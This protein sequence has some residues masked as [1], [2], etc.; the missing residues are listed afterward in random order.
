MSSTGEAGDLPSLTAGAPFSGPR[1]ALQKKWPQVMFTKAM[2]CPRDH[3]LR[4]QR[5]RPVSHKVTPRL[6]YDACGRTTH[7]KAE[8]FSPS[9]TWA[10]VP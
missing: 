10:T 6:G 2:W 1:V 5:T 9:L 3:P 8:P 7:I 4:I